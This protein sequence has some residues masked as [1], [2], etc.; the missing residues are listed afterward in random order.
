MQPPSLC[1]P[2]IEARLKDLALAQVAYTMQLMGQPLAISM[3]SS[4][5]HG[6]C[7][8][9]GAPSRRLL[10]VSLHLLSGMQPAIGATPNTCQSRKA[11]APDPTMA[12]MP[13]MAVKIYT[14]QQ[15]PTAT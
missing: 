11:W 15:A 1:L 8:S 2:A 7:L 10:L 13:S 3:L 5:L 12:C 14:L 4:A 6:A 9:K